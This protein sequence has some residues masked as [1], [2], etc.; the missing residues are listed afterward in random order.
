MDFQEAIRLTEDIIG[1]FERVEGRD[2]AVEGALMELSKQVGE[3]SKLVMAYENYYVEAPARTATL[4]Q[5]GDELADILYAV[6][7]VAR[8]YRID[9]LQA[10]LNARAGE[11]SYLK[12]RGV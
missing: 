2:W 4:D 10:H 1:R 11:D 3:L 12:S 8:H 9:L 6:I 7:R 5:I